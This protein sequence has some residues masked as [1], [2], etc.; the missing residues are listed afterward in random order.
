MY[1]ITLFVVKQSGLMPSQLSTCMCTTFIE[2]PHNWLK[3]PDWVGN[4]NCSH[5]LSNY[6]I[7]A[8]LQ[9]KG[10]RNHGLLTGLLKLSIWESEKDEWIIV[11]MNDIIKVKNTSLLSFRL[12]IKINQD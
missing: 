3:Q 1:S 11:Y 2:R 10:I 4:Y 5:S 9:T 12:S 7:M 8:I 6:K